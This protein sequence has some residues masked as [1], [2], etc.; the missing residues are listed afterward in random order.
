MVIGIRCGHSQ[1]HDRHAEERGII[2]EDGHLHRSSTSAQ[3]FDNVLFR[4]GPGLATGANSS[5]WCRYAVDGSLSYSESVL[6][7]FLYTSSSSTSSHRPIIYYS[8]TTV[9][10][11][12]FLTNAN[13]RI[14]FDSSCIFHSS[15][16]HSAI[17]IQSNGCFGKSRFG[18]TGVNHCP[19]FPTARTCYVGIHWNAPLFCSFP[20]EMRLLS[21]SMSSLFL[22]YTI[23]EP[24]GVGVVL[25]YLLPQKLI[26]LIE[27]VGDLIWAVISS[28][29]S[30]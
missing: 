15:I 23:N 29:A 2:K 21:L 7:S 18:R 16:E 27:I 26:N 22:M 24:W 20:E 28:M 10:H 11:C 1:E 30:S 8:M 6:P 5:H 4:T 9:A 25:Y 12:H 13:L 3:L 19:D 14:E 17:C